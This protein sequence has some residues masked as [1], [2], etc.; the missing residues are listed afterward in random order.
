MSWFIGGPLIYFATV[1]FLYKTVS[2]VIKYRKMPR[3]L[4]WDLNPVPHQGPAGSK[5]QKVDFFK[6]KTHISLYHEL[7]EMSQEMLFI[8][9]AFVNSPKVW[10]GSFPLHAGLYLGTLWLG[11]LIIGALLEMNDMRVTANSASWL[12]LAVYYLTLAAGVISFVTGLYGSL[13]LLWLRTM[14]EDLRFISD[15]VSLVNLGVMIFLFGTGLAA[16]GLTD[17]AFQ[18][19]RQQVA[20]LLAL[21]AANVQEPLIILELLAFCLFLIYLPFSRM[22]H[23][24][25]KYFFYHNIMWDDELMHCNSQMKK[26]ITGYLQYN[27]TWSAQHIRKGQSWGAQV[28]GG[29]P[30]EGE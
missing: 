13:V 16:W 18:L 12:S 4:R 7:K 28:A 29:L 17:P 1:L 20:G 30:K 15:I 19:I 26:E 3:H 2:T 10:H 6:L 21:K 27:T 22:M 25:A 8:K 23:F 24:V 11:L 9:K 5:Y 14:D